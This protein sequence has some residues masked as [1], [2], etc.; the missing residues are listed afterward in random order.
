M[1]TVVVTG[2]TSGIGFAV[3]EALTANGFS[4]IGVGHSAENCRL[5]LEKLSG[6]DSE[7]AHIFFHGDLMQQTEVVRVL[8]EIKEYLDQNGGEL[9]A[10][11]NN[12]G[13]VRSWYMTTQE[14]Y[15][16]QFALNHLAGFLITHELMPYLI[17]ARGKVLFTSSNSHKGIKLK[18]D[19]L[20]HQKNY[21]PLSAYKRSKLCNMLTA[22]A[23]NERF[24]DSGVS[25]YA[26]DPGLV[27]TDIGHKDTGKLVGFVW[28]WR[29]RYGV[30]PEIPA[31]TYLRLCSAA[32]NPDGL[33]HGLKGAKKYSA[34]VTEENASRL[35][36]ISEKLCGVKP[37][38]VL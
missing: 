13:C 30:A 1:K 17:K 15:E 16:Q 24:A 14:G 38:E 33:Y 37:E 6:A 2:A 21:N 10:L 34:E 27:A 29:K 9:H 5:A 19:D 36:E 11:V 4:V 18:W 12:A 26:V 8:T 32:E 35:Y 20:M 31:Q 22:Y 3:C 23:L 7:S 28:K 25:A